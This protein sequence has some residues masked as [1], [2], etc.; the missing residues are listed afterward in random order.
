MANSQSHFLKVSPTSLLEQASESK[1]FLLVGSLI[2]F[3]DNLLVIFYNK[4]IIDFFNN[5]SIPSITMG[6][7]VFF[8]G[9]F[10]FFMA[11]FF[12]FARSIISWIIFY[13]KHDEKKKNFEYLSLLEQRALKEQNPFLL[14]WVTEH[15]KITRDIVVYRNISFSF[16]VLF[17]SDL[18]LGFENSSSLISFLWD[19]F[20]SSHGFIKIISGVIGVVFIFFYITIMAIS[21]KSDSDTDYIYFP[22]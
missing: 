2:L 11:V 7:I 14:E 12:P 5:P 8:F 10:T 18:I 16:I 9:I 17:A 22:Q 15:K 6:N 1:Y 20:R 4:N 3:L 13:V 21:L 19:S